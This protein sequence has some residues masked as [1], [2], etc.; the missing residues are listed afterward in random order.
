MLFTVSVLRDKYI[1][2]VEEYKSFGYPNLTQS[3]ITLKIVNELHPSIKLYTNIDYS[4][5]TFF[6]PITYYNIYS[7]NSKSRGQKNAYF[8]TF[9][10]IATGTPIV[11]HYVLQFVNGKLSVMPILKCDELGYA[12]PNK[13]DKEMLLLQGEWNK[14]AGER[15]DSHHKYSIYKYEY[16]SQRVEKKLIGT[17]KYKYAAAM[18][19]TIL[20]IFNAI[21]RQE[22]AVV[23]DI[24]ISDYEW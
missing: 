5:A 17:T 14:T 24:D 23:S 9:K 7:L 22:P 3:P 19:A 1:K 2:G 13:N 18:N 15:E 4:G 16:H 10:R 8:F 12:I 20:D 6:N 11:E 21:K